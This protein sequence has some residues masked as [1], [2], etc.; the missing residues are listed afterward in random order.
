MPKPLPQ[1]RKPGAPASVH[2][3][4]RLTDD[5]IAKARVKLLFD[6]IVDNP[7]LGREAS[8]EFNK[9]SLAWAKPGY[10]RISPECGALGD[11]WIRRFYTVDN[12]T[13]LPLVLNRYWQIAH[14]T[15]CTPEWAAGVIMYLADDPTPLGW[16]NTS[17]GAR[18]Y[19]EAQQR[20]KARGGNRVDLMALKRDAEVWVPVRHGLV[21]SLSA[22]VDEE[23]PPRH[24]CRHKR[25]EHEEEEEWEKQKSLKSTRYTHWWRRVNAFDKAIRRTNWPPQRAF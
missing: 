21:A 7:E 18:Y 20:L 6:A 8:T 3:F 25:D 1:N 11:E 4:A 13:L 19:H 12:P 16:P 23:E 9:V 17:A 15:V 5:Q 2:Y 10:P 24:Y 22:F 14:G